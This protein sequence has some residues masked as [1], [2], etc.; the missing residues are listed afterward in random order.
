MRKHA[1]VAIAL[2]LLSSGCVGGGA[3]T[4]TVLV[5]FAHDQFTSFFAHYFPDKIS[6]LPGDKVVF[7]QTWTGEPHTV[8]G[9]KLVDRVMSKGALWL[10][11]FH[12]FD[13]LRAQGVDMPDTNSEH[14]VFG[15]ISWADVLHMV[16]TAKP[17]KLRTQFLDFYQALVDHGAPLPDRGHAASVPFKK[18]FED[19]DQATSTL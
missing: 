1:V 7:R 6:V 10:S 9:G 5:D 3:N 19:V 11:F 4:R 18:V 13:G 17:S 8:T 12:A 16:D 14:P 2:L 15:D